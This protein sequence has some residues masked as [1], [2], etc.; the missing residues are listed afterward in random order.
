MFFPTYP[1]LEKTGHNQSATSLSRFPRSM[2]LQLRL[3]HN[4]CNQQPWSMRNRLQF[5]SVASLLSVRQ[6]DFKTL[7]NSINHVVV[8]DADSPAQGCDFIHSLLIN[9]N[10]FS[11]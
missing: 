3:L 11:I 1:C 9:M 10:L 8:C 7:F 5:S 4:S 6:L 2:Q